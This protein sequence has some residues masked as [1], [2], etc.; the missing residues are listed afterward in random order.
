MNDISNS[1]MHNLNSARAHAPGT[2]SSPADI[3]KKRLWYLSCVV[4][5]IHSEIERL[6][7]WAR[8]KIRDR[9]SRW[10]LGMMSTISMRTDHW[11]NREAYRVFGVPY[12]L[13]HREPRV[14]LQECLR[15]AL[16]GDYE[17]AGTLD[18]ATIDAVPTPTFVEDEF[19][20]VRSAVQRQ[21]DPET[22][23]GF[24]RF[25]RPEDR[26]SAA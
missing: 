8:S 20:D 26:S 13:G 23:V 19:T 4:G 22:R 3:T 25:T 16:F 14:F 9:L 5:L 1:L 21:L 11:M 15:A 2:L 6:S 18:W 24:A 10:R 17:R 12:P 7:G